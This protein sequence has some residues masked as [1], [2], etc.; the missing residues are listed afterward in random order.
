M[1]HSLDESVIDNPWIHPWQSVYLSAIVELTVEDDGKEREARYER[2]DLRVAKELRR[3]SV[4]DGFSS[5]AESSKRRV[6]GD[7]GE[8]GNLHRSWRSRTPGHCG[9]TQVAPNFE[10]YAKLATTIS[11]FVSVQLNQRSGAHRSIEVPPRGK[12]NADRR[13]KAEYAESKTR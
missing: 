4:G 11:Q 2:N 8:T 1:S 7:R 3:C 5:I 13:S 9:S 6:E 10:V 12:Y